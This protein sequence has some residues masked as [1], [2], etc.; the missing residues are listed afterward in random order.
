MVFVFSTGNSTAVNAVVPLLLHTYVYTQFP[1][2]E[3]PIQSRGHF[4]C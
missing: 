3:L 2:V 1:E 4:K